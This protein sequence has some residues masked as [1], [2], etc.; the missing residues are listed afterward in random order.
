MSILLLVVSLT[1]LVSA[2]CS[3]FEA[4]LYST[5]M[6]T[7]EAARTGKNPKLAQRFI[8]MKRGIAGPASA[9]L[10]LNTL[11][12]TGGATLSGM[13]GT[14]VLGSSWVPAFSAGLTLAILLFSEIVPKT[15]G[16]IH[17]RRLWPLIVWPL[18]IIERLFYPVV[19][20]TRRLADFFTRGHSIIPAVTEEEIVSMIRLG[21]Q[22]GE[23]TPAELQLLNKIFQFEEL[24][25]RQVMVPRSEVVF[26]DQ[27]SRLSECIAIARRTKHT[28]FPLCKGT[29][30]EVIGVVHVK[31]LVGVSP[32]EEFDLTSVARPM[33]SVPET[34][35]ISRLLRNMQASR[36]H[37]AAVIDEYGTMA[38]IITLEI[39]LEQ[40]VGAV[41]DEFDTEAPEIVLQGP[42]QYTIQGHLPIGRL[43]RELNLELYASNVDTLSGL[44]VSK[45]GRLL[46]VGD[47]IQLEGAVARVLDAHAGRAKRV[48]LTI[49][50]D[51]DDSDSPPGAQGG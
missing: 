15:Y 37:M 38:G 29:L 28:R 13:Y 19:Q 2:M 24:Y 40:I 1:L 49:I 36:Q 32:D 30:D 26:F 44:L 12:N 3:L 6:A 11:A 48:A 43:N 25:C 20:I 16:A 4:T 35:P 17:W 47:T 41:Q 33:R 50:R 8:R 51:P 45:V 31:D 9:I 42:N 18:T 10:I 23:V 7:L 39:V 14:Q 27:K 34:M 22:S 21:A 5:R 46:K